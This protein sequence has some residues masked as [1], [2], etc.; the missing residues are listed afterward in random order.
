[1]SYP[2]LFWEAI[3][4]NTVDG[5]ATMQGLFNNHSEK[6]A[7]CQRNPFV[8][9]I[10]K[11][12]QFTH[13]TQI[14][15]KMFLKKSMEPI[16]QLSTWHST[17]WSSKILAAQSRDLDFHPLMENMK[18]ISNVHVQFDY[19]QL[20]KICWRMVFHSRILSR[21]HSNLDFFSDISRLCGK[22]L[23]LN[24]E[25][26]KNNLKI[27]FSEVILSCTIDLMLNFQR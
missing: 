23:H 6:T 20:R 11:I 19:A 5:I 12:S 1:M 26:Q 13:Q 4:S 7:E 16:A 15:R 21:K 24:F 2:S 25:N 17:T 8:Y 22:Y 18:R 27:D 9:T 14:F 10:R 3:L